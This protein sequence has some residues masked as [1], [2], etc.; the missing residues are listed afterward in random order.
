MLSG[1]FPFASSAPLRGLNSLS[2]SRPVSATILV[3]A[4]LLS[5]FSLR[6]AEVKKIVFIA[7]PP[8][9][10]LG[11]H[12]YRAGCLLLKGCLDHVPGVSPVVYGNG[13]PEDPVAAFTDA[14]AL[15]MY[16]DGRGG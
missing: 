16:S 14:A 4:L 11:E 7:G 8:S 6:A 3:L 5:S 12:E 10:G 13:W 9:H 15:V 2:A 1:F